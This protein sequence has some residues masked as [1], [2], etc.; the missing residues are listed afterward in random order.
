MHL[1][2]LCCVILI[3]AMLG[4]SLSGFASGRNEV[5]DAVFELSSL[6]V[7]T[8]DEEGNLHLDDTMTRGEFAKIV[9]VL[10]GCD[11]VAAGT[12]GGNGQMLDVPV[13][14][15]AVGYID[16]CI[17]AG[18]MLGDGGGIFRPEDTITLEECVKTLVVIM[19]YDVV[20]QEEGG[21][22][23]GYHSVAIRKH[24]FNGV[25]G[26]PTAPALRR[27]IM[28]LIWNALDV[29]NLVSDY[30]EEKSYR[31]DPELTIR[32]VIQNAKNIGVVTG[33]VTANHEVWLIQ[34][35]PSME[36]NQIEIDNRVYDV[37]EEMMS[38]ANS[39]IGQE[40]TAYYQKTE[41]M[42]NPKI[43]NLQPT[44]KNTVTEVL[45][46]DLETFTSSEITYWD[47][48]GSR[49]KNIRLGSKT[50]FFYNDRVETKFLEEFADIENG[51]I[52]TIDYNDDRQVD[53]VFVYE[54]QSYVVEKANSNGNLKVKYLAQENGKITVKYENIMLDTTEENAFSISDPKG[55][56][57][58]YEELEPGTVISVFENHRDSFV[59]VVC[60]DRELLA[61]RIA[62]KERDN[63]V[64]IDEKCFGVRD[65]VLYQWLDLSRN[66]DFSIDAYGRVVYAEE[67][68]GEKEESDWK[69]GYIYRISSGSFGDKEV[70][71]LNAG[72]V[73]NREE[74]N[75]EDRTDKD[76][77][78]VTLC[79]NE[80][81]ETLRV[82]DKIV[83]DG[84]S[85]VEGEI[86][87]LLEK[88]IWYT[89]NSAGELKQIRIAEEVGG[90]DKTKYNA[91]EKVFGTVNVFG[92]PF[93]IDEKTQVICVPEN[94]TT[95]TEDL[96]V[97]LSI[98]NKDELMQ[99]NAYGYDLNEDTHAV[100]LLVLTKEM[101]A[102][103]VS[104]VTPGQAKLGVVQNAAISIN[105]NSEEY[106]TVSLIT[107]TEVREIETL[108]IGERPGLQ[109]ITKGDIIFFTEDA[110]GKM[111]NAQ[112][113]NNVNRITKGDFSGQ[114]SYK[115]Q[116][117]GYVREVKLNEINNID[118]IRVNQLEVVTA[119]GTEYVDVPISN[120]PDIFIY[121][122]RTETVEPGTIDDIVSYPIPVEKPEQVAIVSTSTAI[123]AIVIIK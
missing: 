69:Y 29:P 88:P 43:Y 47:G 10:T 58:A 32:S 66:Y 92:T 11:T 109:E 57:I 93:L 79:K 21:Y 17:G 55:N 37:A 39:Y 40:V 51:K 75:L 50:R 35:N 104:S 116:I 5:N 114:A 26:A 31:E 117:V 36:E 118:R 91:K 15:W 87:T 83:I 25:N 24:L 78:P 108:P 60:G 111:E 27:D 14:H 44:V 72:Q 62:V 98:D 70:L 59:K 120:Y 38:V 122:L 2:K 90:S 64:I 22:P 42:R 85:S 67:H 102:D 123:R 94:N 30:A 45:A 121:N 28:F 112:T 119:N 41:A 33:Q 49:E 115:D 95:N 97:R 80:S 63:K 19:G 52:R 54:Y 77:V 103:S 46:E 99:Y 3:G 65:D 1:K 16:Y 48:E 107:G 20:A 113:V 12:T 100:K 82:A 89:V 74:E 73:E 68:T 86:D 71:M 96:L 23:S 61:G 9:S 106:M 7:F 4:S 8:G 81:I 105:E 101:I 76:V 6:G 18:L 84:K 110:D 34:E 53:L 13:N 56:A